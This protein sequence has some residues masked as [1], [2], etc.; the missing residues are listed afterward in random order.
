MLNSLVD[1]W[2]ATFYSMEVQRANKGLHH[3]FT[4]PNIMLQEEKKRKQAK[5]IRQLEVAAQDETLQDG[6]SFSQDY[7]TPDVIKLGK[8]RR[9]EKLPAESEVKYFNVDH[10]TGLIL[11]GIA[12][13]NKN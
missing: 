6:A 3:L 12:Y 10:C 8:R 2:R 4:F 7:E 1:R 13:A 11:I 9:I 5:N